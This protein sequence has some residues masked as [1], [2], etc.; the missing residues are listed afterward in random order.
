MENWKPIAFVTGYLVSDKG[1]C[2]NANSGKIL[3]TYIRSGYE[4]IR[5]HHQ[6]ARNHFAIHR[7]VAQHFL[8]NPTNLPIVDHIDRNSFNNILSNLRWAT[9]SLNRHNSKLPSSNT[10]GFRGVSFHVKN[11]KWVAR[12]RHNKMYYNLGS[13]NSAVEAARAYDT[14]AV[15]LYGNDAML[16]FPTV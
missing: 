15:E 12:I 3:N 8:P 5:I 6:G 4:Y 7:L 14:K 9:Q 2:M 1:R 16:N 10:T 11:Q 13:F